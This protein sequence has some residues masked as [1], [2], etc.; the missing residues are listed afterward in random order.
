MPLARL[1]A[2]TSLTTPDALI[3]AT[4]LSAGIPIVVANDAKWASVIA[5]AV[6]IV[7]LGHLDVHVPL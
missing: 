7:T 1:R 2:Q 5:D 3:I 4:V 6:P